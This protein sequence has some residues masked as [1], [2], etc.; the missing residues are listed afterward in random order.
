[1]AVLLAYLKV[2]LSWKEIFRRTLKEAFWEDNCLGM[3]AQLA[4][5]FFFA[6]F[7]ALLFLLALASY[8]PL[9]TLIDEMFRTLGSFVPPEVLSIIT[10]QI[11][12]ISEGE[13]TG[14]LTLGMLA[15]LWSS[16]AAM[17]AIIDTLNAAYDVQEGRPWWKVR[18]IAIGLTIGVALFILL[19]FALVLVGPTM[20][21][22]I[23]DRS[24][25][26]G[27]VFEWTWKI[28]QWPLVFALASTGIAL[29]YYFAPDVEQ[30][31]IWLTP[32]SL[33]ATTVWLIA[34]LGFKYYVASSM[35]AYVETYGAIGGVMV[36]LL[37]FYLSGLAILIGAE[38]NAE[39]EHASPYGKDEG[40]K[41]PGE[42]RKL[43]SRV[44]RRWIAKRQQLGEKPPSAEEVKNAVGATPPDK[45]PGAPTPKEATGRTLTPAS[46]RGFAPSPSVAPAQATAIA[47]TSR[48]LSILDYLI[49]A[50]IVA[51]QAWFALT[52]R[53]KQRT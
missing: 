3:A 51:A 52:V 21:E 31:W 37:W 23:A 29:I 44:M 35:G 6:L 14:L 42:K 28:V 47:P 18:L 2:P 43:G 49:G 36:L 53:R 41:V 19:S 12:K 34:S 13:Q 5:Y 46:V 27:P 20:A 40:E 9:T 11:K 25:A 15:T 38:L 1:M 7:P 10:D 30:G 16:S 32:G 22:T 8:F 17:T 48:K 26:L 45:E 33:F 39:I 4:Y 24:P 50:G